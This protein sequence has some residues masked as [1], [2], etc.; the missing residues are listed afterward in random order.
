MGGRAG[1]RT[2]TVHYHGRMQ[3]L[4]NVYPK[5]FDTTSHKPLQKPLQIDSIRSHGQHCC[6]NHANNYG[7]FI[8]YHLCR[9]GDEGGGGT[10]SLSV[11]SNCGNLNASYLASINYRALFLQY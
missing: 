11:G 5:S 9:T 10:D 7:V 1:S 8:F 3:I 6:E 2:I 4:V